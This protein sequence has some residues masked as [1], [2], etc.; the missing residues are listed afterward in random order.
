[1]YT[2]KLPFVR[3]VRANT[4]IPGRRPT[5]RA[6]SAVA[7]GG[8]GRQLPR[9]PMG[10]LVVGYCFAR[11]AMNSALVPVDDERRMWPSR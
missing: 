4:C 10:W 2:G 11:R 1:M 8:E 9:V 3:P 7:A 6:L 5:C